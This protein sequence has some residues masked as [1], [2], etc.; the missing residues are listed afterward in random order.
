MEIVWQLGHV[1]GC[2][3]HPE[4]RVREARTLTPFPFEYGHTSYRPR[5]RIHPSPTTLPSIA[6]A[7]SHPSS[8]V[9]GSCSRSEHQGAKQ[10]GTGLLEFYKV[11][12]LCQKI[13]AKQVN[14]PARA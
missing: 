8:V 7:V 1:V 5:P 10:D 14:I 2:F 11:D 3:A 4:H 13:K 9:I 12:K 6:L